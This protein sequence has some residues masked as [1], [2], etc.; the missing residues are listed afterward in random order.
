MA[1]MLFSLTTRV[2][3]RPF[4]SRAFVKNSHIVTFA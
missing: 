3:M 4:L 1:D 2:T